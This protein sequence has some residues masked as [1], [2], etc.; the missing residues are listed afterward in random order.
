MNAFNLG[1]A[2]PFTGYKVRYAARYRHDDYVLS[3][4]SRD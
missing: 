2:A 4:T 3:A 1:T